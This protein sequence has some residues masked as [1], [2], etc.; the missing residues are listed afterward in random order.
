MKKNFKNLFLFV[1]LVFFAVTP[2]LS[3]PKFS[4]KLVG[5]VSSMDGGD[6]NEAIKDYNRL[7]ADYDALGFPASFDLDELRWIPNFKGELIISLSSNFAIGIG[8]EYLSKTNKGTGQINYSE[9]T[10]Y[11]DETYSY[12]FDNKDD[13]SVSIKATPILLNFYYFFPT[14][15][16]ITAF[17]YAGVAYYFASFEQSDVYDYDLEDAY[18]SPIW[19]DW[20]STYSYSGTWKE[21][22]K[23]DSFGFQGG[24]GFE[25]DFTSRI[26]LVA[27]ISGRIANF[28][29][30][31][32]DR[33]D[34][35]RIEASW[36]DE[37]WG[38][39][40]Y[41]DS[42]RDVETGKLWADT[43]TNYIT[44]KSYK[45]IGI[46]TDGDREAKINLN[47]FQFRIGI[48]IKI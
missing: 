44:D 41:S 1:F 27:E 13:F 33:S 36:W 11:P 43:F 46:D 26:A 37:I 18:E 32:G 7:Y 25:F 9:V 35:W 31:S 5:G 34:D 28:K 3:Q 23:D 48:R 29:N 12:E 4:L 19:A 39:D 40:S 2:I 6:L 16:K 21:N 47:G 10:D 14:R 8:T 42:G 38:T 30:W 22:A 20:I 45:T 24:L 15:G 17:I